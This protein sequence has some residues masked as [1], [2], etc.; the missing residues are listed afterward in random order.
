[1]KLNRIPNNDVRFLK[2]QY[3]KSFLEDDVKIS[4]MKR[5]IF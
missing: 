3:M 2:L 5:I 4:Q 1:M